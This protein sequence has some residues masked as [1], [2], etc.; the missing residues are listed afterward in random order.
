MVDDW[1]DDW[2]GSVLGLLLAEDPGGATSV[3]LVGA[4]V[5]FVD[6]GGASVG[7]GLGFVEAMDTSFGTAVA[8][9][10]GR[11]VTLL[12]SCTMA[13]LGAEVLIEAS[14]RAMLAVLVGRGVGS[15]GDND[16]ASL[17]SRLGFGIGRRDGAELG[18]PLG[19][20]VGVSVV[21]LELGKKVVAELGVADGPRD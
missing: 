3:R 13:E 16:G 18:S 11:A 6:D 19:N 17:G 15:L 5:E 2:V 14:V 1:A 20:C 9:V 8:S 7:S 12:G 4:T 21:G 10:L